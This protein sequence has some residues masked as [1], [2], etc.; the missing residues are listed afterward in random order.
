MGL[1]RSSDTLSG[2]GWHSTPPSRR[3]LWD[4]HWRSLSRRWG[5]I[6]RVWVGAGEAGCHSQSLAT[7]TVSLLSRCGKQGAKTFLVPPT[8]CQPTPC[9][10][11]AHSSGRTPIS[12]HLPLSLHG[13][14]LGDIPGKQALG[15]LL[16]NRV[17]F[18]M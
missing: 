11:Q 15:C 6:L 13:H 1:A 8:H 14:P 5:A 17:C 16:G 9:Y 18:L 7:I 3:G 10:F 4:S 2:A 12:P